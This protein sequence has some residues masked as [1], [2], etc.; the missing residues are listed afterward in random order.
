VSVRIGLV[1]AG[2]MARTHL[3]AFASVPDAQVVTVVSRN[4][5]R[6]RGLAAAH[7]AA[8]TGS[9]EQMLNSDGV[10]AV[11]LCV[12]TDL[13]VPMAEAAL[14]SGK[15]VLVEKPIALDLDG[16]DRL[17]A[18]AERTGLILMVGM[19]LRFWPEY[20]HLLELTDKGALGDIQSLA[21]YRL[22]APPAWNEWMALDERSGGVVVDLMI[23]DIDVALAVAGPVRAVSAVATADRRHVHTQLVHE[24]G[25]VSSLEA[26]HAMPE[27]YPF[28]CGYRVLGTQGAAQY[29]FQVGEAT[30]AGNLGTAA[31]ARGMLVVPSGG[32]ASQ[33][34]VE[35]ADPFVSE[36]SEFVASVVAGNAAGRCTPAQARSALAVARAITDDLS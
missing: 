2:F 4:E 12:P 1:G 10:D 5:A 9:F 27:N 23:H 29:D 36:L 8:W 7:N 30:G 11:D 3:E 33:L 26:S 14:E 21:A 32:T 6:G 19:V 24:S 17:T 22:S 34:R 15:H 31:S 25:A 13:H 20:H 18:A 35:Q 28:S 16:A